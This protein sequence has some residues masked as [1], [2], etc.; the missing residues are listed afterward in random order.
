MPVALSAD[1]ATDGV[2]PSTPCPR[3]RSGI[4]AEMVVVAIAGRPGRALGQF[5]PSGV[6]GQVQGGPYDA[7]VAAGAGMK[8]ELSV[9]PGKRGRNDLHLFVYDANGDQAT[10]IHD[11]ER[12]AVGPGAGRDRHQAE[13]H[14][15]HRVARHRP[16]RA[17]PVRGHSGRSS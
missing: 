11:L 17:G 10:D 4:R 12:D 9:Y 5:N 7:R 2:T 15:G 1:V 8:A 14:A 13:A 16:E 6:G 3:F